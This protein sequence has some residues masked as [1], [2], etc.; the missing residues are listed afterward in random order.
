[1]PKAV[2]Y[3]FARPSLRAI[4]DAG[5]VGVLRYLAPLPN[6]KVIS[7]AE[8]DAILAAG[9]SLGVV[10]ESTASRAGQGFVAGN[11][12]AVSAEQMADRLGVPHTATIYY[13]VDYDADPSAIK[14]YFEGVNNASARPVGGYG[15]FRVVEALFDW[16]LIDK[17]WQ[18][19]AWSGGKRSTRAHLYQRV[20]APIGGTDE[21][22]I[23]KPDWGQWPRPDEE[24]DMT[25]EEHAQLNNIRADVGSL[26]VKVDNAATDIKNANTRIQQATEKLDRVLA[27]L[28]QSGTGGA[29]LKGTADVTVDLHPA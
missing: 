10:W 29:Q 25:P 20:G 15:S 11:S 19:T 12:D 22:D 7:A 18:A 5:Y 28:E 4:K 2:D 6:S 21:N 27:D 26:H 13:A 17:G 1:M 8:R 23:L 16:N 24:V 3:S 14:A 9:L